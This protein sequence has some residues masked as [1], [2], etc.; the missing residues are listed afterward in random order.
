MTQGPFARNRTLQELISARWGI[1]NATCC[2]YKYESVKSTRAAAQDGKLNSI[3]LAPAAYIFL[4]TLQK[5]YKK[6]KVIWCIS[7]CS[8][9]LLVFHFQYCDVNPDKQLWANRIP[10]RPCAFGHS[11]ADV[12]CIA[13]FWRACVFYRNFAHSEWRIELKLVAP[14]MRFFFL[15]LR[16]HIWISFS[17]TRPAFSHLLTLR[18]LCRLSR[19]L[20]SMWALHLVDITSV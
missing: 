10:H 4:P 7:S 5:K 17:A 18:R 16:E 14:R 12:S 20:L 19:V 8:F 6:G 11:E 13:L 15:F 2:C 9:L 3:C 1:G